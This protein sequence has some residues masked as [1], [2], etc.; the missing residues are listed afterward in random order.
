MS[1]PLAIGGVSAVLRNLLDNGIVQAGPAVGTVKVTALA[2][3]AIK[4]NEPDSEPSLNLFLY[5]VS[6]NAGWRNAGLPGF[7]SAG[8]RTANPPLALD[9]HYLLTAYGT[10]DFEAEILLGYA[11]SILHDQ[12]VLDRASIRTAL[13]AG[14]VSGSI[15]PPAYQALAA[16]DLADQAAELTVTTEPIDSEEMS[17]LWS[18]IQANYRPSVGYLVTVVLIEA[19]KPVRSGLP[20]LTRGDPAANGGREPGV[21]VHPDLLP[22]VPT[23][24]RV[25]PPAPQ[26]AAALGESVRVEG[27]H[28]DGTGVE[29]RFSHPALAAPI[30]VPI[31]AN[32][33]RDVVDV[34]LPASPGADAAWPAG[35]WT[36]RVSLTPPTQTIPRETN[37]AAMLLAPVIRFGGA[38]GAVRDGGT[39]DVTATIEVSPA[40][41]PGQRATLA[42]GGD[43]AQAEPHATVTDTLV[44]EY[45]DVPGGPQWVRLAVDGA[46]SRLILLSPKIPPDPPAFDPLQRITV[47]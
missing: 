46:E 36:V 6:P 39:G 1:G 4:L 24:F 20:V 22:P 2:P 37:T 31:G 32:T 16:A 12:P 26:P 17:R 43:V 11:M 15:L 38:T 9:L 28:L 8:T 13:Q 45:G 5:R 27:A 34:P 19:T 14:V 44:F 25:V 47:P 30:V 18:A 35:V 40:V 29:V 10:A 33:R 21:F 41:R 3:D 23:V 42:L 7:D